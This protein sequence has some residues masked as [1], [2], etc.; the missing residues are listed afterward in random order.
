MWVVVVIVGV[1]LTLPA[2]GGWRTSAPSLRISCRTYRSRKVE[3]V[4][5]RGDPVVT[6]RK[7]GLQ[8]SGGKCFAKQKVDDGVMTRCY[9]APR[10]LVAMRDVA[11]TEEPGV[12]ASSDSR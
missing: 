1:S 10:H 9:G 3:H 7:I 5:R 6:G 4:R 2:L 11:G 8:A 12:M